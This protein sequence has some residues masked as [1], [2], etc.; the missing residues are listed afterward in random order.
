M[1]EPLVVLKSPVVNTPPPAWGVHGQ[2]YVLE[3]QIA[4]PLHKS[5]LSWPPMA[6]ISS[7][8]MLEM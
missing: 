3:G 6:S 2:G 7:I 5:S 4:L 1:P 8:T